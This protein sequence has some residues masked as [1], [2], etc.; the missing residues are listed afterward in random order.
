MLEF[1]DRLIGRFD[2]L[3]IRDPR[4]FGPESRIARHLYDDET[5]NTY[6]LRD[7]RLRHSLP[8]PLLTRFAN[9]WLGDRIMLACNSDRYA[10]AAQIGGEGQPRT[11]FSLALRGSAA[12]TVGARTIEVAGARGAI[13]RAEPGVRLDSSDDSR[14]FNFWIA[15]QVLERMLELLLEDRPHEPL[16]FEPEFDWSG[17]SGTSLLHLLRHLLTELG[18]DDGFAASPIALTAFSECVADMMLRRFPHN[19]SAV[20]ARPVATAI[21]RQLR[22]AEAWMEAHADR[23][24]TLA[25]I[26]AASGC[27]ARALQ[28]A[29][30]RFR[31]TTPHAAQQAIRLR[32]VRAALAAEPEAAPGALARR[33]GFT[34]ATRFQAVY[35]RH[36]GETPAETQRRGARH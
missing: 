29:F 34:N 14:R 3:D 1:P 26:A 36:F 2:L 15:D 6:R 19:Y 22:R 27:S 13:F 18:E 16:R 23:P 35:T 10:V 11:C 20:L 7:T 5:A 33:F 17:G 8:G 12:I 32:R 31:E 28:G 24:V 25:E 21:P 30:R 9:R 4:D